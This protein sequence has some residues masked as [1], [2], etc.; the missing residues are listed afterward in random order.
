TGIHVLPVERLRTFYGLEKKP[1]RV[2]EPYQMLGEI[3]DDL[4]DALGVDVIGINPRNNMFGIINEGKMKEFKTF[5]DQEVLVHENF[6]TT[7][8][9][10]GDLFIHPEGDLSVPPSG[11]MPKSSFFFDAVIRQEPIDETAL[12]PQD[13]LEEFGRIN[14]EDLNYWKKEIER[15]SGKDKAIIAN[16]GGTAFGDIAIVPGLNLK[17]PK[18][19]RD[20]AEWYM[21]VVMRPDYVHAIFEK[22]S[23]IALENLDKIYKVVGNKV[24]AVFSR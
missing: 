16:F 14:D 4:M 19:I 20:I 2:I 3:D 23:E 15:V 24:D 6:N 10:N 11:R 8:D 13:N 22:Q 9:Q 21:S 12:D 5:W 18:G 17:H 1:V 7:Y